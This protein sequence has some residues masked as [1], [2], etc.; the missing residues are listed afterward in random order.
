MSRTEPATL[1]GTRLGHP[2]GSDVQTR[3][4]CLLVWREEEEQRLSQVSACS[5][6]EAAG[7]SSPRLCLQSAHMAMVDALMMAYTVE[8][9]S[10]EK[11]VASVKRFSTFSASKELPYDLEDAMVFWVNKVSTPGWPSSLPDQHPPRRQAGTQAHAGAAGAGRLRP[12]GPAV[13]RIRQD[14]QVF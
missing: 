14:R 10:I 3:P 7:G 2:K 8:M 11:V 12:G 5:L 4:P 6:A 9:I 1:Q 13:V